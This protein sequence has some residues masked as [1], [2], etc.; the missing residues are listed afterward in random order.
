MLRYKLVFS[1]LDP[2]PQFHF[3]TTQ[4][5]RV[6]VANLNLNLKE[7]VLTLEYCEQLVTQL[8]DCQD[9]SEFTRP[10]DEVK[11]RAGGYLAAIKTPMDL[12]TLHDRLLTGQITTVGEFKRDLDLIWNNCITFNGPDHQLSLKA[13]EAKEMIDEKWEK[14]TRPGP[15]AA[16]DKVKDMKG[17]LDDLYAKWS[18]ILKIDPRPQIP[19]AKKFV[20]KEKER[21]EPPPKPV[22]TVPNHQQRRMMAEKLSKHSYEEMR[23]AW[24]VIKPHL[25]PN[26]LQESDTFSLNDL[27]PDAL[28]ELKKIVLS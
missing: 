27:P 24:E 6:P 10:V 18:G 2:P 26:E 4:A 21:E 3:H 20:M 23:R 9:L 28:I 11:D 8:L 17:L 25:K 1:A 16:L 5:I 19:P 15:S 7:G 14:S 22:E 12:K 13:K